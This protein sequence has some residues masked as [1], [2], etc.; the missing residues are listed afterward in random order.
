MPHKVEALRY[1]DSLGDE[2]NEIGSMNTIVVTGH[3]DENGV[4]RPRLEGRNT[5]TEGIRRALLA[6]L[7]E[8]M[9]SRPRPFGEG[10]SAFISAALL[11]FSIQSNPYV[12]RADFSE[13]LDSRRRRND[14]RRH[15]RAL[16]AG[17]VAALARQSRPDRNRQHHRLTAVRQIRSEAPRADRAMDRRRGGTSRLR[18]GRHPEYCAAERGRETRVRTR[19]TDLFEH[20]TPRGGTETVHGD[21]LQAAR[22]V[23]VPNRGETWMATYRRR[24]LPAFF[25]YLYVSAADILRSRQESKPS[26]FKRRRKTG[27]GCSTRRSRPSQDF[28][29]NS[30]RTHVKL[31]LRQCEITRERLYSTGCNH[32]RSSCPLSRRPSP[33]YPACSPGGDDNKAGD[34]LVAYAPVHSLS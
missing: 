12:W 30:S 15:S 19:G 6:T 18:S 17:F 32:T 33:I 2:V 10:K 20:R 34:R 28:Q 9:R 5:D 23:A 21:G 27:I 1:M 11:F 26:S 29:L 24:V 4:R 22:H 3:V 31:R 7:A 25:P 14:A 8:E 16:E 13:L